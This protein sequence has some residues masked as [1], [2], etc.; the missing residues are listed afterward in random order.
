[1]ENENFGDDNL[2]KNEIQK[3]SGGRK[4]K[5]TNKLT[6]NA[7]QELFQAFKEDFVG[8]EKSFAYLPMDERFVGLKSIIKILCAG[9]DKVSIKTKEIVYESLNREFKMLKFYINQLPQ[10]KK[11]TEL[12]QYLF[13]LDKEQIEE[14]FRTMK[15]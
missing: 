10:N 14:V 5:S 8:L 4:L 2:K 12:R 9:N 15:R 1:M 3:S 7:K 11:A 6:K 13:C